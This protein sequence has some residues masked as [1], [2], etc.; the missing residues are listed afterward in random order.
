MDPRGLLRASLLALVSLLVLVGCSDADGSGGARPAAATVN[1]DEI[2][3]AEV[4]TN[5]KLFTF[6]A[7]LNGAPCGTKVEGETDEAACARFA[8]GSLIEEHFVQ[9]YADEHDLTVAQADKDALLGQLEQSLG[10][11]QAVDDQLAEAGIGRPELDALTGRILLF[12]KV[13]E[14]IAAD[15]GDDKELRVLYQQNLL[16]FTTLDT[17]HILLKTKAEAQDAYD[18]VTAPG[19]TEEDFLALAGKIS[20]DPGAKQNSGAIGATA[21]TG[22]DPAYAAAAAELEPGEISKP[23]QSQFGWHVI[24]LVSKD[25]QS[26][27]DAKGSLAQ[28]QGGEDFERWLSEAASAASIEVNPK[29][30]RFNPETREVEAITSTA[31]GSSSP[32]GAAASASGAS[33][34]PS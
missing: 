17:Q 33:A 1:G 15:Q 30:G 10:G 27:E 12:Q 7:G 11:A 31:T 3:D 28:Q 34:P 29:Y 23:V 21:A 5:V 9:T 2:T 24:R 22:L 26:F 6:L 8:I 4:A 25:V 19:A 14:A 18:E 13:Q 16:Q 32:S 20:T